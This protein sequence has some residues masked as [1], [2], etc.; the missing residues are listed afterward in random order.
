MDQTAEVSPSLSTP[1]RGDHHGESLS[2]GHWWKRRTRRHF[3]GERERNSGGLEADWW[4][5]NGGTGRCDAVE[6]SPAV[7]NWV[8]ALQPCWRLCVR[9]AH[10]SPLVSS[11]LHWTHISRKTR[12]KIS[13]G[14][15]FFPPSQVYFWGFLKT[16]NPRQENVKDDV[17]FHFKAA[18][19]EEFG[20]TSARCMREMC[21][22]FLHAACF[23]ASSLQN[24]S[25]L[26][27]AF[28]H[29]NLKF[30]ESKKACLF[31]NLKFQQLITCRH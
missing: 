22:R 11:G 25:H 1:G 6:Q 20:N 12:R 28:R 31:S 14:A 27:R 30:P 13:N 9:G 29:I 10:W 5:T 26:L 18:C 15:N 16:T 23:R 2:T 19:N 21:V 7:Q 17:E 3:S 8:C 24:M 4:R